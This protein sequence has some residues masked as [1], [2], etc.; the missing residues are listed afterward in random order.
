MLDGI[1]FGQYFPANSPIHRLDPRTKLLLT[2]L[3]IVTLFLPKGFAALGIVAVFAIAVYAM[4]RVPFRLALRSI[5][6]ILPLVI[7]MTLLN[8]LY[9][10]GDTVLWQWWAFTVSVEG[11]I[12]ALFMSVRIILLIVVT[13]L[14]TYTT[15]P[16][17]LTDGLERLLRPLK[18]IKVPVHDLAMIMTIALRFIPTLMEEAN[19]IMAAQKARGADIDTGSFMKRIKALIPILVPLLVSAVRRA[20]ELATAMDCRCYSGGEGRTQMKQIRLSMRDA[21]A[22]VCCV[23]LLIAVIVI[24]RFVGI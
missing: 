23:T 21:V 5:K 18:V 17:D 19:K 22:A 7:I 24:N 4:S 2:I 6:A 14:L 15:N 10:K 12:Q 13:S 3:L 8:V 1:S 11:I 9:I 20:A 16:I